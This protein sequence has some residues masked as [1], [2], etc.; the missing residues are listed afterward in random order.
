M[1]A[2]EDREEQEDLR[3]RKANQERFLAFASKHHPEHPAYVEHISKTEAEERKTRREE[4][5]QQPKPKKQGE[6]QKERCI[7]YHRLIE[8]QNRLVM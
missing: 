8:V 7:Y 2:S 1:P 5:V 6:R 4:Q 3:K